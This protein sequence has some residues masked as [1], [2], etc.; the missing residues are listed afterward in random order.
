MKALVTGGRRGIGRAIA[1]ALGG[2]GFDVAVND[3]VDSA[4]LRATVAEVSALGVKAV[5]VIGD[6]SDL[7][8]HKAML[9]AAEAALGPL[10]TLVNNAGVSVQNRGD[11]LDVTAESY[12]RC[13]N[14]NTRGTFFLTQ[15]FAR[16]LRPSQAHRSIVTI[17]SANASGVS[18]NRGEYCISKAGVSMMSKLFAAR[19]GNEGVGVYEIQPGFIETDMT[20]PSKA[21]Y[22][23]LID[24]GL[25]V[26]KRFGT[27]EEVGRI[28]LTLAQGLLP[29]TTGQII[30]ADAGLMMVRY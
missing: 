8:A 10:T 17:S 14:V 25:T 24:E 27:P 9:D 7:D 30:Q 18:V 26:I 28:A 6:I 2:A 20:A 12:D 19:L 1:H 4:E 15:A 21:R 11:L 29:Y 3:V 5:A 16:R 13:L 23:K 22:D